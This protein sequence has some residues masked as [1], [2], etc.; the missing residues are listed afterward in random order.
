MLKEQITSSSLLD[1]HVF[2]TNMMLKDDALSHLLSTVQA[3]SKHNHTKYLKRFITDESVLCL[4]G[5][6][7]SFWRSVHAYRQ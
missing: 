1:W 2:L 4:W 7:T 3:P 5:S 6:P